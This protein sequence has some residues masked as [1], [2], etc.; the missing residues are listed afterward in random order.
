MTI[1]KTVASLLGVSA[2]AVTA[3]AQTPT[4]TPPDFSGVYY[5][6]NPFGGAA[7]GG[8]AQAAAKGK[9]K[10][11]PP[12]PTRSAP[13]SDGSQGRSP[14]APSLTPEY[15]AKW[16]TISKSR[17]AGSYEYDNTAKCLPPGMPAMMNMAY[18]MEVMQIKDK[19][20]FFSELN[21][22]LR[23][24]YLDGRKPTQKVLDDP[25]YAGYSTGHWEGDTLV[26][27]TVALHTN[28]FI[29][30]FSPHS[31]AMTVKERIRFIGPDVLED[32][33]VVTDPK[34]L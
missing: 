13:L 2:F 26:V 6:I 11:P 20:T 4:T 19:I 17:I 23:R 24:V 7:P 32:R 3:F 30:G 33:I 1:L 16:Q 21:D 28:S 18:G 34:A 12:R 27:E 8:G 31:D 10:A 25:T 5:P 29:E 22:A 14:D 15:M 9:Q